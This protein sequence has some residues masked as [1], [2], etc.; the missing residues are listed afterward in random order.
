[1]FSYTVLSSLF[2]KPVEGLSLRAVRDVFNALQALDS[3]QWVAILRN[4]GTD[5]RLSTYWK[6]GE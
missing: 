3:V 1:M 4:D 6:R 5:L 2:A